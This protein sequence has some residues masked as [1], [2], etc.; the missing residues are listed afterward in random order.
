MN[1]TF[2][3]FNPNEQMIYPGLFPMP[4]AQMGLNPYQLA[5]YCANPYMLQQAHLYA[6]QRQ[7]AAFNAGY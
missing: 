2:P 6:L 4:P 3:L 1:Q 7:E 5:S